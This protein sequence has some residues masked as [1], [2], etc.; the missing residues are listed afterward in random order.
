MNLQD[1]TTTELK[2]LND[3]VNF[4]LSQRKSEVEVPVIKMISSDSDDSE[5]FDLHSIVSYKD[6]I[7]D[8]LLK[9][10]NG[11]DRIFNIKLLMI[12]ESD[13]NDLKKNWDI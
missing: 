6:H 2:V 10:I 7:N 9:A 11:K 5:F 3:R 8:S 1:K 12:P 4:E 13:Y